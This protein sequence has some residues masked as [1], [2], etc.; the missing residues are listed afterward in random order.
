MLHIKNITK[1]YKTDLGRTTAL[2]DVSLSVYPGELVALIGPSGCGKSTLLR[3]IAGLDSDYRGTVDMAYKRTSFVFQHFALM[4]HMTVYE[5]V[6]FGLKMQGKKE[7]AYTQMINSLLHEVG[8]QDH[9][10]EFPRNL[11]GGMRQRVGIARALAMDP[12]L[13]LM[14]EPFSAL[15]EF[16]ADKL[17]ELLL[18]IWEK[19]KITVVLVTHLVREALKLADRIVVMTPSPGKIEKILANTL[20]RPRNLRSAEFYRWE[21][22]LMELIH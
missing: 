8:L 4:P 17:R 11:S 5:N 20:K 14:D 12:D 21:D 18:Q 1:T 15:D 19:R 9:G 2:H 13:L 6:A 16:T 3:I 10:H 22:E 7:K